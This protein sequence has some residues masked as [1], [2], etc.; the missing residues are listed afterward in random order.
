MFC[1]VSCNYFFQLKADKELGRKIKKEFILEKDSVHLSKLTEF[2]W[3][4]IITLGPYSNIKAIE[5]ELNIDLSNIRFNGIRH[6]DF[7]SL[8]VFLN[9]NK[10]VK[11]VELKTTRLNYQS[12]ILKRE[13][14]VFIKNAKGWVSA[15]EK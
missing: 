10:C 9:K 2:D 12:R 13:N 6:T 14:S 1:F 11:I 4:S 5:K 7:Y 15:N 8:L 3:D